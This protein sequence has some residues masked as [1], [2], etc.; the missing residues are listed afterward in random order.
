M[1]RD[2]GS[3]R[4]GTVSNYHSCG[5]GVESVLGWYWRYIPLC[6][7]SHS[8]NDGSQHCVRPFDENDVFKTRL[9][10]RLG[11]ELTVRHMLS[12]LEGARER[13][14]GA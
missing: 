6:K 3:W 9:W 7:R 1:L 8:S 14:E 5:M 2:A 13:L 12:L 10:P 4:E 11:E